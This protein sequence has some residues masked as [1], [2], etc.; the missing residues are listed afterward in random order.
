[1]VDGKRVVITGT[2]PV[3]PVGIGCSAFWDGLLKGKSGLSIITESDRDFQT[4][5]VIKKGELELWLKA[6]MKSSKLKRMGMQTIYG[7]IGARLAIEDARLNIEE[8]NQDRVGVILGSFLAQPE[9]AI[10]EIDKLENFG[11]RKLSAYTPIAV[12]FGGPVG[13]ISIMLG[14][15]GASTF[16]STGTCSSLDAIGLAFRS[17]QINKHDVVLSGGVEA[18]VNPLLLS[19]FAEYFST[20]SKEKECVIGEGAGLLV[21]EEFEHA[22]KR[23][24][25]AY[26]EIIGYSSGIDSESWWFLNDSL[27]NTQKFEPI[28]KSCLEEAEVVQENVVYIALNNDGISLNEVRESNLIKQFFHPKTKTGSLKPLIGNLLGASGAMETISICHYFNNK[29][30]V[31]EGIHE[32]DLNALVFS[33]D[34]L[35][36]RSSFICLRGVR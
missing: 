9:F 17:I 22:K 7:C 25:R 26:A 33:F 14:I 27:P 28:L 4:A 15:R 23:G 24:A 29:T 32:N 13:E 36:N 5:G 21:I 35:G 12:F 3:S 34:L 30:F 2:G 11:V 19:I 31:S 6:I 10:N 8:C 20:A 16:V 1:M 18:P